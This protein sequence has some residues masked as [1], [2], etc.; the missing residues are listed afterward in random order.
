MGAYK[1]ARGCD[2]GQYLVQVRPVA[3]LDDRIDP[4]Q[5]AVDTLELL[6]HPCNIVGDV[7]CALD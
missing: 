7:G 1:H 5:D 2:V 4:D 3:A 6:A